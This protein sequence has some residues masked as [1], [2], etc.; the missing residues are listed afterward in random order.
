MNTTA[1][2][3]HGNS[4]HIENI[5]YIGT[6]R[7]SEGNVLIIFASLTLGLILSGTCIF[8]FL[9]RARR[10]SPQRYGRVRRCTTSAFYATEE[11]NP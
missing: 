5:T 7:R 10:H 1:L 9:C 3:S 2:D 11:T 6:I 4:S 8:V